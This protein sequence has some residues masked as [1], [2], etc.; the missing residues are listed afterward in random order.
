MEY[1]S[2]DDMNSSQRR[3][4]FQISTITKLLFCLQQETLMVLFTSI[5]LKSMSSL[6]IGGNKIILN[7][8]VLRP[9]PSDITIV[10]KREI[11][12]ETNTALE[13]PLLNLLLRIL[14]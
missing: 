6:K 10:K 9:N 13:T 1:W 4:G 8:C 7:W 3:H 2:E 5:L 11:Y 12:L 14:M